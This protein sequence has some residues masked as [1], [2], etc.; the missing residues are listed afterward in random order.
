[1]KFSPIAGFHWRRENP[2]IDNAFHFLFFSNLSENWPFCLYWVS[3]LTISTAPGFSRECSLSFL[4]CTISPWIDLEHRSKRKHVCLIDYTR[5]GLFKWW[6]ADQIRSAKECEMA[7]EG[8]ETTSDFFL[9]LTKC[10]TKSFPTDMFSIRLLINYM[11]VINKYI[12]LAL[13]N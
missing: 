7:R 2:K 12:Y 9:T 11:F 1:M 10:F 5:A 3:Y 6:P 13:G 8:N 4:K